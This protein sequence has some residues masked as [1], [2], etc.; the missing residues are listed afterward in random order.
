[1]GM[2]HIDYVDQDFSESH[3]IRS[4]S[5]Q[6]SEGGSVIHG[7]IFVLLVSSDSVL[8]ELNVARRSH[9]SKMYVTTHLMGSDCCR[10]PLE[11][12]V[13]APVCWLN[14]WRKSVTGVRT[15]L[16]VVLGNVF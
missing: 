13:I 8:S 3:E 7:G 2:D 14:N 15:N 10:P 12:P 9:L 1:M 16:S 11:S 6:K 4:D 5:W